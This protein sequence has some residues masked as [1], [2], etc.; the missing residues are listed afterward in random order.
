MVS[1]AREINAPAEIRPRVDEGDGTDGAA[2][3]LVPYHNGRV[4]PAAEG[5]DIKKHDAVL[6]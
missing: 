5:V 3:E 1:Q 4:Y 2:D 6:R